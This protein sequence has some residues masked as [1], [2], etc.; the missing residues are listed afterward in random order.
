ME[1]Y[2][3]PSG[4]PGGM[5]REGRQGVHAGAAEAA[6]HNLIAVI[7]DIAAKFET[8]VGDPDSHSKRDVWTN[9]SEFVAVAAN[10]GRSAATLDLTSLGGIKPRLGAI[11][12]ARKDCHTEFKSSGLYTATS[13]SGT[14]PRCL[15]AG[16]DLSR[17]PAARSCRRHRPSHSS[18]WCCNPSSPCRRDG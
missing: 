3:S 12:G 9:W 11:S 6:K 13:Q 5:A 1:Y 2:G 10:F 14:S 7:P 18:G 4:V 8:N 16:L 17:A 15:G